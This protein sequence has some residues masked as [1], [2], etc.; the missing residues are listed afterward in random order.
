[1]VRTLL[2]DF[3]I[4]EVSSFTGFQLALLSNVVEIVRE[5]LGKIMF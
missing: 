5:V 3:P 2:S 1:M 4:P